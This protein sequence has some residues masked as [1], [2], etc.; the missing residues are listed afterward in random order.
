MARIQTQTGVRNVQEDIY[1]GRKVEVVTGYDSLSDK[2]PFHIYI[3]G[4]P[5]V[6]Q[7]K[8]DSMEEA[9]DSGFQIA[10]EQLD[11]N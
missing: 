9:F 10:H 7:F 2:W 3:D 1:K 5:L 8:A 11:R 6:G 4:T